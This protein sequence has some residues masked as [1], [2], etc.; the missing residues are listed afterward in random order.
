MAI[1]GN[2]DVIIVPDDTSAAQ[3]G[4]MRDM[5][6]RLPSRNASLYD[7][8]YTQN[9]LRDI[10]SA[11]STPSYSNL[12]QPRANTSNTG[13]GGSGNQLQQLMEALMGGRGTP[14]GTGRNPDPFAQDEFPGTKFSGTYNSL[15]HGGSAQTFSSAEEREGYEKFKQEANL[16]YDPVGKV[17]RAEWS[18]SKEGSVQASADMLRDPDAPKPIDYSA[19]ATEEDIFRRVLKEKL[20]I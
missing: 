15:K 7:N 6:S 12:P 11:L 17:W 9:T 3:Y 13:T 1:R 5:M 10:L 2:N 19:P 20:G 18:P 16:R 14:S 4:Y 8:L